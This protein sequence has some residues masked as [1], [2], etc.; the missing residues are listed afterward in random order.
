MLLGR[1]EDAPVVITMDW[2][3]V[4]MLQ[5]DRP[6]DC[7]NRLELNNEDAPWER[8][9]SGDG[10]HRLFISVLPAET[11][12]VGKPWFYPSVWDSSVRACASTNLPEGRNERWKFDSDRRLLSTWISL[13]ALSTAE[14]R[15]CE[16]SGIMAYPLTTLADKNNK[17]FSFYVLGR[18]GSFSRVCSLWGNFGLSCRMTAIRH[19]KSRNLWLN[20]QTKNHDKTK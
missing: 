16:L 8:G 5:V 7:W 20:F 1:K 12:C 3:T 11:L 15:V 14:D 17:D 4:I 18:M 9:Y 10:N 2:W 19:H 6:R 13:F